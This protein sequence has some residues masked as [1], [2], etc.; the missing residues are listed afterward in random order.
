[1]GQTL[2]KLR[3]ENDEDEMQEEDDNG[4]DEEKP[5]NITFCTNKKPNNYYFKE[6]T[7][8]QGN[9][10]RVNEFSRSA[11]TLGFDSPSNIFRNTNTAYHKSIES[12]NNKRRIRQEEE[13]E[14]GRKFKKSKRSEGYKEE[15]GGGKTCSSSVNGYSRDAKENREF[16]SDKYNGCRGIS[17]SFYNGIGDYR[18]EN[19]D[20]RR[21]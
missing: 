21:Q 7:Q 11:N 1:M 8:G 9:N 3:T 12:N 5:N 19:R 20:G 15:R 2:K 4:M 16:K 14:E 10:F 17:A 6:E 13:S 18:R